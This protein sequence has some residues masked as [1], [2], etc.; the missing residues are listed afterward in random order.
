MGWAPIKNDTFVLDPG[1]G[2][3][4]YNVPGETEKFKPKVVIHASS[5]VT[6]AYVPTSFRSSVEKPSTQSMPVFHCLQSH[7]LS[8]TLQCDLEHWGEG[9][10]LWIHDERTIGQVAATGILKGLGVNSPIEQTLVRNDVTVD[11]SLYGCIQNC[12]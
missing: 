5:P 11:Y 3:T 1:A 9:Y 12:R 2:I 6:I 7:V 8:T 4:G 10:V